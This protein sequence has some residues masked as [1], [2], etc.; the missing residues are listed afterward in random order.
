MKPIIF[1]DLDDVFYLT[2]A[3]IDTN[4]TAYLRNSKGMDHADRLMLNQ[5]FIPKQDFL[6]LREDLEH[7]DPATAKI[8]DERV[9]EHGLKRTTFI[10]EAKPDE[11]LRQYVLR[12]LVNKEVDLGICTH[13]LSIDKDGSLTQAALARD[14]SG[15]QFKH[16]YML[17]RKTHPNK[18]A[19][20]QKQ[21][22]AF[23]LV[24]DNPI[25][26]ETALDT[27]SRLIIWDKQHTIPRYINQRKASDVIKLDHHIN[28]LL[29]PKG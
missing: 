12:L 5:L 18:V 26:G 21:H 15:I 13:R 16:V 1:F 29:F 20:L 17:D 19:Y 6:T 23:V 4:M 25:F 22:G 8:I 24:D 14:Y 11:E 7:T 10:S 2:G 28:D 3:Y 9:W 27:D